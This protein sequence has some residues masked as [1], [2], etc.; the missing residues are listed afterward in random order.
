MAGIFTADNNT[1]N[2]VEI[3]YIILQ[4]LQFRKNES[5]EDS[6]KLKLK[7]KNRGVTTRRKKQTNGAQ[8]KML[9]FLK[10]T[11]CFTRVVEVDKTYMHV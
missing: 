10:T 4:I 9:T 6:E 5:T 3:W 2:V 1:R 7:E 11:S 8:K